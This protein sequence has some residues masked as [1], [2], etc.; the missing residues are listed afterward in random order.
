M[1]TADSIRISGCEVKSDP[2]PENPYHAL[3]ILPSSVANDR[4]DQKYWARTLAEECIW[5]SATD[6]LMEE[7]GS[8]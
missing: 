4:D 2:I 1:K 7:P 5:Q 3:I 6:R 8:F